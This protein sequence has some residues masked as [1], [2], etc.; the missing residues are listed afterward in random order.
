MSGSVQQLNRIVG[1]VADLSRAERDGRQAITLGELAERLD[2]STQ[3]LAADLRVLTLLGETPGAEWLLSLRVWQEGDHLAVSSAGPFRRP[4]R[5]LPEELL[6]IQLGLAGLDH[7]A[8]ALREG[9]AMLLQ[10]PSGQAGW[11]SNGG[12]GD[13][14]LFTRAVE[15][16][17][18][19][20]VEY[21]GL[22]AWDSSERIIQPHQVVSA[23]GKTYVV[24]WCERAA[25]WRR[26]RLDRMLDAGLID[27]H[28]TPRADFAPVTGPDDLFLEPE[29]GVDDVRVRFSPRV[30]RWIRERHPE[31]TTLP[32]G[33]YL[34]TYRVASEDWLVRQ[35][36]QYGEDAVVEAPAYY[37]RLV[38][39]RVAEEGEGNG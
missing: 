11:S 6:A 23:E 19:V 22:D 37:R 1:L 35:V 20:R 33:S 36:L 34:V 2:V 39:Q 16:H 25:G 17:F 24:A 27:G 13:V 8:A 4:I 9:L 10:H 3:Q 18:R 5:F 31:G 28:F 15:E 32:D 7:Q 21:A 26:F 29:D 30:S 38:Q 12:E 14:A